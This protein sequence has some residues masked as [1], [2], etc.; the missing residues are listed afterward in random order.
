MKILKSAICFLF[1]AVYSAA[2]VPTDLTSLF[3]YNKNEPLDVQEHAI[4]R[5]QSAVL[6][7][8]NYASSKGS[9]VTGY[10]VIPTKPGLHPGIVFGHWGQGNRQEFLPEALLYAEGGVASIMI[11]YPWTRPLPWRKPIFAADMSPEQDRDIAAQAVIDLRRA[12]D[13]LLQQPEIDKKRIVYVGHSFGAQWG[14]ILSAVDRR[15]AGS[16]LIAIAPSFAAINLEGNAP[17]VVEL[18][19]QV[20]IEA[21]KREEE[22]M[23]SLDAINYVRY[24]SPIPLLFQFALYEPSFSVASMQALLDAARGP[25]DLRWYHS[26]HELNDPEAM[27]DR[28]RWISRRL[29]APSILAAVRRRLCRAQSS[30]R[31]EVVRHQRAI[32][33]SAALASNKRTDSGGK[34]KR[35]PASSRFV[36]IPK[37]SA[38]SP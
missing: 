2:Q 19:N 6:Y 21:M 28:A 1:L 30:R 10:L 33:S 35:L 29:S 15:M 27:I 8:I 18:R 7:D 11:D 5:I 24:A 26:G 20:G 22:T 4:D 23:R 13:V 9:R 14:A 37:N 3:D 25:K 36:L 32:G 12:F 34:A 17:D 16:V 31:D 38:E